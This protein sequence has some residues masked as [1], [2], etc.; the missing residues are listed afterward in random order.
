MKPYRAYETGGGMTLEDRVH[1]ASFRSPAEEAGVSVLVAGAH[2]AHLLEEVCSTQGITHDQYN[3]LRILRGV[4]PDG[5][6][7][8]EIGRR[9]IERSPDVTRLLDRLERAGWLTRKRAGHDRRVVE[10]GITQTGLDL[11]ARADPSIAGFIEGQFGSL[12]NEEEFTTLSRFL[13]RLRVI[14][15]AAVED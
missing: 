6:P 5:H 15:S 13:E 8:Y 1:Q 2:L 10:V 7:R 9:L 11:L 12:L 14:E 4:Y 3:V